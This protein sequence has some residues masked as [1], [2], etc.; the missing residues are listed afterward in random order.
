MINKLKAKHL[1]V[2]SC[3]K[4]GIFWVFR[5]SLLAATW[6]LKDGEE[7]GDAVNGLSDHV[8]YWPQFQKQNPELR[9]LEY[10]EVPRGRVLFS[11]AA[12]KFIVY[13]DKLLHEPKIKR[14]ILKKF[15]LPVAQTRFLTDLHYTTS[16]EELNRIFT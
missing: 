2:L 4:V 8:N 12:Q 3:G 15:D 10:Q 6:A 7:Y 5:G 16:Q 9:K 13:M 11:K 1:P 14:A